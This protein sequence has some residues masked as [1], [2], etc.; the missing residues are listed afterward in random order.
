[1]LCTSWWPHILQYYYKVNWSLCI[2]TWW[3]LWL[4]NQK[5]GT[6][7]KT[8]THCSVWQLLRNSALG[9]VVLTTQE[10]Q[11]YKPTNKH[12]NTPKYQMKRNKTRYTCGDLFLNGSFWKVTRMSEW[13]MWILKSVAKWTLRLMVSVSHNVDC[14][15]FCHELCHIFPFI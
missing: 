3:K 4:L 9:V 10:T 1:M 14:H 2:W 6:I 12:K 11:I 8:F 5:S 7:D 13:K 15:F